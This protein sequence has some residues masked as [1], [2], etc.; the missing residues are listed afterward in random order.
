MEKG[1][2]LVTAI[3]FSGTGKYIAA[4][5]AAEQICVHLFERSGKK[6]AVSTSKINMKVANLTWMPGAD[7]MFATV[8]AKHLACYPV[9]DGKITKNM[10][11]SSKDTGNTNMTCVS[12]CKSS[13]YKGQL[14]AGGSDGKIYHC[15]NESVN[16]SVKNGKGSVHSVATLDDSK[17]GGEILLV[18]G[19]D[20]TLNAY[21]F[22]GKLEK[23]PIWSIE[24]DSPPRSIDMLNGTILCGYK[25]G[26]LT[27]TPWSTDGK[28]K[29]RVI[30]TSHCDGEV[31]GLNIVDINGK[32]K[33]RAIT[34]ADDNRVLTYDIKN[35][36]SLAEGQVKEPP[37]KK[38]KAK[39]GYKGGASSMSSAPSD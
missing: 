39:K 30:M 14:F 27:I 4:S 31:W 18:G 26:S 16:S 17:A 23:S 20:K 37:K 24:T 32:G 38:K 28:A 2:R 22:S 6:T 35:H 3:A 19:N 15:S 13:K 12:W 7:T 34:S 10:K 36:K 5:D 11:A 9:N 21:K 8:G 33:L 25:N 29:P 1:A